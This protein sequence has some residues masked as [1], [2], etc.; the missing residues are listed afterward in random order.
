MSRG[1]EF[2]G[3]SQDVLH[4]NQIEENPFCSQDNWQEAVICLAQV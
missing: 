1:Q 3:C 2:L 4:R